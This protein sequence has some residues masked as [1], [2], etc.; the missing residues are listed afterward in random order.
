MKNIILVALGGGL[1]ASAR[2]ICGRVFFHVLGG[3]YPWGT[4]FVNVFGG[5]LIGVLIGFMAFKISGGEALRLFLA[6]GFLGGFT[7]FSAFSVEVAKM[8]ET[9]ELLQ[10]G[11]Y[12]SASVILSV[13]AVFT[14]L[15]IARKLFVI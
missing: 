9:R 1:G 15:L 5:L 4:L 3:G 8:L 12:T 10:A 14:G 13:A 6:V 7:T 11:I 2:Y